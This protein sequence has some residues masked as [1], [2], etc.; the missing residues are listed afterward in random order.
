MSNEQIIY[1]VCNFFASEK[2]WNPIISFIYNNN[3]IFKKEGNTHEEYQKFVDFSEIVTDII[4]NK[5]SSFIGVTSKVLENVLI[6]TYEDGNVQSRVIIDTLQK[7]MNYEDFK[8]EMI[9]ASARIENIINELLVQI[10]TEQSITDPNELAKR[11]TEET[12]K[13]LDNEM[14]ELIERGCRQMKGLLSI[15]ILESSK[16]LRRPYPKSPANSPPNLNLKQGSPN[17]SSS[18]GVSPNSSPKQSP[19]HSPRPYRHKNAIELDPH[20]VER[21]RQF[22]IEQRDILMKKENRT[23]PFMRIKQSP[24]TNSPPEIRHK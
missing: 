13:K 9:S 12:Q 1:K 20:E 2:W 22:Y 24:K 4:D 14:K 8:N 5:L 21:R 15:D 18:S 6:G 7:T 19:R 16:K 10:S 11:V 23:P 17:Q 3:E